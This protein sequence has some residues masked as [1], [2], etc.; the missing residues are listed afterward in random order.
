M[1]WVAGS[2][3]AGPSGPLLLVPPCFLEYGVGSS[4]HLQQ[5]EYSRSFRCSKAVASASGAFF[6]RSLLHRSPWGSADTQAEAQARESGRQQTG[7]SLEADH[8]GAAIR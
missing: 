3:H 8:C 1:L 4:T 2:V 5:M 7:V 6:S